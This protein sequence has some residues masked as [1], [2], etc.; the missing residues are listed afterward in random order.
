MCVCG[1]YIFTLH[2]VVC[3]FAMQ[4]YL[5]SLFPAL[6]LTLAILAAPIDGQQIPESFV[7]PLLH[8]PLNL[9]NNKRPSFDFSARLNQQ[10]GSTLTDTVI[11]IVAALF[12]TRLTYE[13]E[14]PTAATSFNISTQCK[15]DSQLYYDSY[16]SLQNW[17]LRS[18]S[19]LFI[20]F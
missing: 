14:F 2:S 6:L 17:A 16:T 15:I 10:K 11:K 13:A 8:V 3:I 7:N 4:Q 12:F 20:N 18:I 5:H 9:D 1:L 19:F